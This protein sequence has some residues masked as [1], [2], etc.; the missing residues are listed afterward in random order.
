MS[1]ITGVTLPLMAV[2]VADA[3]HSR[4]CTGYGMTSLL[5]CRLVTVQPCTTAPPEST[6]VPWLPNLPTVGPW[7]STGHHADA[8]G[9]LIAAV[10]TSAAAATPATW[11]L[12]TL[13][14]SLAVFLSRPRQPHWRTA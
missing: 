5:G 2:S 3:S 1:A 14:S 12:F 9:A 13:M 11:R 8:V 6:S 7:P 4:P 10:A